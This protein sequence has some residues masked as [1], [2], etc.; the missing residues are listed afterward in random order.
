MEDLLVQKRLIRQ[1]TRNGRVFVSLTDMA[2]IKGYD[3]GAVIANWFNT[4]KTLTFLEAW[5][6]EH[7]PFAFNLIESNQ[8]KTKIG[9][10]SGRISV[11]KWVK[12]TNAIGIQTIPGGYGGTF[13]ALEI[14]N[15]FASWLSPNFKIKLNAELRDWAQ[16]DKRLEFA[17]LQHEGFDSLN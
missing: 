2:K 11:G 6:G 13:A 9:T 8:I 17:R 16:W 14:A 4:K 7:N 5:E 3:T 1:V 10:A 15:E 12:A